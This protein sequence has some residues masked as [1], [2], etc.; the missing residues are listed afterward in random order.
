MTMDL[1]PEMVLEEASSNCQF[2]SR[3]LRGFV[4]VERLIS[5]HWFAWLAALPQYDDMLEGYTSEVLIQNASIKVKIAPDTPGEYDTD[6]EPIVI[7][8]K[9]ALQTRPICN[10]P[11]RPTRIVIHELTHVIDSYS[12]KGQGLLSGGAQ[13]FSDW[14]EPNAY[15]AEL[16]FMI[17]EM[18]G[19]EQEASN[20][21][22]ASNS[23]F[24][25]SQDG[26]DLLK[27][28]KKIAGFRGL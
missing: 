14:S 3:P 6:K 25:N 9:F 19:S 4:N 21:V 24:F 20:A 5:G 16:R 7:S 17:D 2:S 27:K 22:V 10:H 23:V 8:S 13:D 12:R 28:A 18:S 1:A 26:K 11:E 15:A